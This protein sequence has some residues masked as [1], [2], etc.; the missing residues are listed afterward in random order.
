MT[1]ERAEELWQLAA[2]VLTSPDA[3][4]LPPLARRE[5][6]GLADELAKEAAQAAFIREDRARPA[7]AEW[8]AG[9]PGV[10]VD[11]GGRVYWPDA[12]GLASIWP[13]DAGFFLYCAPWPGG[14]PT[15][16]QVL[17]VMAG[18]GQKGGDA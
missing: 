13:T 10:V 15:R 7:D 1:P 6:A 5:L 9:L 18:L 8:F 11:S 12:G 4:Q 14:P 3:D 2:C 17:D 16:G